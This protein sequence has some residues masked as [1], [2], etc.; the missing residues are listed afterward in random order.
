MDVF[1]FFLRFCRT[2]TKRYR[3]TAQARVKHFGQIHH[4]TIFRVYISQWTFSARQ[5]RSDLDV[6]F[7]PFF[8]L[9]PPWH[10]DTINIHCVVGIPQTPGCSLGTVYTLWT[11]TGNVHWLYDTPPPPPP[12]PVPQIGAGVFHNACLCLKMELVDEC[13]KFKLMRGMP[14]LMVLSE[15]RWARIPDGTGS[16]PV[17]G[18]GRFFPHVVNSVFCR[19]LTHT[20]AGSLCLFWLNL[21]GPGGDYGSCRQ[22]DGGIWF[23]MLVVSVFLFALCFLLLAWSTVDLICFTQNFVWFYKIVW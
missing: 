20:G 8:F 11:A 15:T 12:P 9:T 17:E 6:L 3:I 19:S 21:A 14:A 22:N 18:N 1:F 16:N 10:V 13:L 2:W 7:F 5:V 4:R 23:T